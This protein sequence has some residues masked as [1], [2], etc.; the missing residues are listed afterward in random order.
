MRAFL[1]STPGPY[2]LNVGAGDAEF[3]GWLNT[4]T[5]WRTRYWLNVVKP[6]PLSDG[7]CSVILADNVIEHMPIAA[8]RSF[9]RHAARALAPGGVLRI[10]TPDAE[11]ATRLYLDGGPAAKEVRE[12]L[13]SI[14]KAEGNHPAD[15]VRFAFSMWGHHAG[16]VYDEEALT[17]ELLAAN[18]KHV[19]RLPLGESQHPDLV[20][21]DNRASTAEVL[22]QMALEGTR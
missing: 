16:Y 9:L 21:V 6:W 18:F 19:D 1:T 20:A 15:I 12:W 8:G 17:N 22:T 11:A 3:P 5:D 4:D 10:V 7:S 13:K 2:K 14:D